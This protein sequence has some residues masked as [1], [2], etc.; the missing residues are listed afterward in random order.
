MFVYFF[1]F[2][3][4]AGT[5]FYLK[6][7]HE[8]RK[9]I[10]TLK[11]VVRA[12]EFIVEKEPIQADYLEADVENFLA[13]NLQY[14][15]D[16]VHTQV[17]VASSQRKRERVDI[18]IGQGTLG[19]EIKLAKLLTRANERNRLLGQ[20]DLYQERKY[21]KNNLLLLLV[22]I[23]KYKQN[24]AIQELEKILQRKGIPLLYLP[25]LV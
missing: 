15:F 13:K 6:S 25:Q 17:S 8:K 23:E 11:N 21:N 3:I 22:G 18:D 2:L 20:L 7:L 1:T 24:E 14:F 12:I 10:P 16:Q 4:S 5:A 9:R 19:I